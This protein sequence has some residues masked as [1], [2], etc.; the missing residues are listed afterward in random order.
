[1]TSLTLAD[2]KR[3]DVLA[4]LHCAVFHKGWDA[5]SVAG[6]LAVPGTFALLAEEDSPQ[7]MIIIRVVAEQA[8]LVTLAVLPAFRRR[9]IAAAL[10]REA[11]R[12]AALRGAGHMFLEVGEDNEAALHLYRKQGFSKVSRRKGYY[13]LTGGGQTDALLMRCALTVGAPPLM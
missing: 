10:L 4:A 11:L 8:D 6:L 9:G 2:A 7:G 1:M 5:A 12:Q 13:A 3:A